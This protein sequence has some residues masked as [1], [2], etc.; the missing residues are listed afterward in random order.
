MESNPTQHP[1]SF[2]NFGG[3]PKRPPPDDV[4][5]VDRGTYRPR[6]ERD[7]CSAAPTSS[8]RGDQEFKDRLVYLRGTP[9]APSISDATESPTEAWPSHGRLYPEAE[10][11]K[12]PP[13]EMH[14]P[15][16]EVMAAQS[17]MNRTDS[18]PLSLALQAAG[19][20]LDA[21]ESLR[22]LD[23]YGKMETPLVGKG[24][25]IWPIDP[26]LNSK[27]AH[28]QVWLAAWAYFKRG[29]YGDAAISVPGPSHGVFAVFA[30]LV[31]SPGAGGTRSHNERR[32][33]CGLFGDGLPIGCHRLY[34]LRN[35]CKGH[36]AG[37]IPPCTKERRSATAHAVQWT[38]AFLCP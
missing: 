19:P 8:T 30:G 17:Y 27:L 21:A 36:D 25:T 4:L 38:P 9:H 10:A 22:T 23:E 28:H 2:W 13:P 15:S 35:G 11:P 24:Y 14:H 16:R 32:R 31:G 7:S 6:A 37:E 26:C 29:S 3:S 34:P 1:A 20:E 33:L 5:D 18:D 12:R